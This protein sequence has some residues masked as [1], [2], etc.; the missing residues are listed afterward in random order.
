MDIPIYVADERGAAANLEAACTPLAITRFYGDARPK[1]VAS[2]GA[3]GCVASTGVRTNGMF[4]GFAEVAD[5]RAF[6]YFDHIGEYLENR[7]YN[8]SGK[9]HRYVA[10]SD[11]PRAADDMIRIDGRAWR[12]F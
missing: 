4:Y 7:R 12:P 1:S 6:R 11:G 3:D 8:T 2:N 10:S 5:W 9:L